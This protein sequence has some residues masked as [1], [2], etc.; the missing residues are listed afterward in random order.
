MRIETL[1]ADTAVVERQIH[2]KTHYTRR[3]EH[4]LSRLKTNQVCLLLLIFVCLLGFI[5][6]YSHCSFGFWLFSLFVL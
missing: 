1:H 2:E 6:R 5:V 4:M 3:L